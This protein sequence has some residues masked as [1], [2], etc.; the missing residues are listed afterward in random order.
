MGANEPIFT[1]KAGEFCDTIDYIYVSQPLEVMGILKMPYDKECI[2]RDF[3]LR[4]ETDQYIEG[5]WAEYRSFASWYRHSV[6]EIRLSKGVKRNML[7]L[8]GFLGEAAQRSTSTI[9][10]MLMQYMCDEEEW[11]QQV[12]TQ[13]RYSPQ[14]SLWRMVRM[15]QRDCHLLEST[16]FAAWNYPQMPNRKDPS[17]HLA[18][19]CDLVIRPT[20]SVVA[21]ELGQWR[22][23]DEE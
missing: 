21:E 4:K 16:C 10:G 19:C 9:M 2:D 3:H 18:L 7:L 22:T 12:V 5:R 13:D 23:E 14:Q 6:H 17:D 15:R 1:N 8:H 20:G 11:R